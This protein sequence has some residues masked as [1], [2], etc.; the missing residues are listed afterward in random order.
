MSPKNRH[1]LS[2][3]RFL[4]T[5]AAT[6]AAMAPAELSGGMARRV[7]LAR[8]MVMDPD[9]LIYDGGGGG[10]LYG[11]AGNDVIFVA[12]GNTLIVA[13]GGEDDDG[14]GGEQR[15]C[16]KQLSAARDG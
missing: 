15:E 8:A 13:D 6:A 12:G 9:I 5:S 11:D 3:R 16:R 1:S 10:H 7:A 2:R 4:T 14:D